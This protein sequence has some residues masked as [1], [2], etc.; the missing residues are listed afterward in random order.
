[1]TRLANSVRSLVRA[2]A[3]ADAESKLR[4]ALAFGA[5]EPDLFEMLGLVCFLRRR[6]EEAA[7]WF[8]V[9]IEM[10]DAPW[11]AWLGRAR[12]CAAMR[13]WN[14]AFE[15]FQAAAAARPDDIR[16]VYRLGQAALHA[17][18]YDFARDAFSA[19]VA[20]D[21]GQAA[22]QGL[23]GIAQF[24]RLDFEAAKVHLSRA[25]QL[26][27]C[28]VELC[29]Y[30]G[31]ALSYGTDPKAGEKIAATALR[32]RPSWLEG[33]NLYGE[34]LI[35]LGRDKEAIKQFDL[36][37]RRRPQNGW[38]LY[39]RAWARYRATRHRTQLLL[40]FEA[41]ELI[42][43]EDGDHKFGK[44]WMW[45]F[46]AKV[47]T[48]AIQAKNYS[49]AVAALERANEVD[50]RPHIRYFLSVAYVET[51]QY[52]KA[53]PFYEQMREGDINYETACLYYARVLLGLRQRLAAEKMLRSLLVWRWGESAVHAMLGETLFHQR[54]FSDAIEHF[55]IAVSGDKPADGALAGLA[56]SYEAQDRL[57]NA[58]DAYRVAF[59][60]QPKDARL[61][62][63]LGRLALRLGDFETA[64]KA[65]LSVLNV[66]AK[67]TGAHAGLGMVMFR[68]ERFK[69]AE[70]H[71]GKA[72]DA[73]QSWVEIRG[74]LGLARIYRRSPRAGEDLVRDA[75]AAAPRW[76]EG[77]NLY[78][79]L[80]IDL[81]RDRE[82]IDLFNAVLAEDP[83]NGWARHHRA[84]ARYRLDH[85][86]A[87]VDEM[88]DVT[89]V[90]ERENWKGVVVTR[91][92]GT[93]W[94][95][96]GFAYY[97]AEEYERAISALAKAQDY[98]KK[99]SQIDFFLGM[100]YFHCGRYD[101]A[102][103]QFDRVDDS[104]DEFSAARFYQSRALRQCG[105]PKDAI[106]HLNVY[107]EKN[108]GDALGFTELG[109]TL[110]EA[111]RVREAESALAEA[112][113]LDPA[114]S[115]LHGLTLQ[116][117][118]ALRRPFD[119]KAGLP[120]IGYR[121]V[122]EEFELRYVED[123]V[124]RG[125][126]GEGLRSHFRVVQSFVVREMIAR[127][128]DSR[129]GYALAFVQPLGLVAIIYLLSNAMGRVPPEG[130]TLLT[131]LVT[132]IVAVRSFFMSTNSRTRGA[133]SSNRRMLTFPGVTPT[134][135]YVS[136]AVLEF[137]TALSVFW[138]IC[139]AAWFFLG[140]TI[141]LENVLEVLVALCGISIIGALA[142]SLIGLG[143]MIFPSLQ[144]IT[145]PLN[146]LIFFASGAFFSASE[147]PAD[148][149][150]Y[151]MLNPIF[152]LIE[153]VREGFF[154]SYT[155]HYASWEYP[156][157]FIIC[158]LTL[159]TTL[160]RL[161]RNFIYSSR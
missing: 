8:S 67:H 36:V 39:C 16:L 44:G 117:E 113:Q 138:I 112:Y 92:C 81:D 60:R 33:R 101:E 91:L 34:L 52:E 136:Y 105:R 15:A 48:S 161:T 56:R 12:A 63:R 31:F 78:G 1:M 98:E 71:L 29:G 155:A 6:V 148:L 93:F 27:P 50:P 32:A 58:L 51:R 80:L 146:R 76:I 156:V 153:F 152:H 43:Q 97:R 120:E 18:R 130:M 96:P 61:G 145:T 70:Y 37:L 90:L 47:G 115:G 103:E 59:E 69:R 20:A 74:Y 3:Y 159:V 160:E 128:A 79:A 55:K 119:T 88:Y 66:R 85:L 131:F 2:R 73:L 4:E 150:D 158:M 149:R 57:Q 13:R 17:Y 62:Y 110:L 95:R 26:L 24:W 143:A 49:L 134:S 54:R 83:G 7:E 89:C 125:G 157:G 35:R 82:A 53:L 45:F 94:A 106:R 87:H 86:L 10:A 137:F 46:W 147:L 132:G 118:E 114:Q 127:F 151:L 99:D 111:G 124:A 38:A 19:V 135:L 133:V 100:A 64:G 116:V 107:C 109:A 9:A 30:L 154:A 122:P 41:A 72:A 5:D 144:Y 123:H 140:E 84:W 104:D 108:P 139:F 21:A 126:L 65:F 28:W 121:A 14:E 42:A 77:R 40:M 23:L 22:A 75:V 11:T 102:V 142:G 68:T 129:F 25:V 141:A